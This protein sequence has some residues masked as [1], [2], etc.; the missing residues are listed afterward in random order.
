LFFL[1]LD[2]GRL[3]SLTSIYEKSIQKGI[4]TDFTIIN[5]SIEEFTKKGLVV[6]NKRV[7]YA[8]SINKLQNAGCILEIVSP[9]Q[10]GLSLRAIEAIVFNKKLITN[11]KAILNSPYYNKKYMSYFEFINDIDFD[12]ILNT[13][14]VNYEYNG[15]FSPIK[16]MESINSEII[17]LN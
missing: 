5:E 14:V 17:K 16:L 12:F 6:Q 10:N 1:G 8:D 3:S 4:S 2:K 7:S 11:N 9:D 15:D 13:V